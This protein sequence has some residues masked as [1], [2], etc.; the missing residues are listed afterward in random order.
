LWYFAVTVGGER[1]GDLE[2][3]REGGVREGE[4]GA[5]GEGERGWNNPIASSD[6]TGSQNMLDIL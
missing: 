2:R 5:G 6:E 4:E 3:W 1:E